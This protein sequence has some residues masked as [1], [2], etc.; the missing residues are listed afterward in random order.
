VDHIDRHGV[1]LDHPVAEPPPEAPPH[2]LV[3]D[4]DHIAELERIVAAARE[5][6]IVVTPWIRGGAAAHFCALLESVDP[7]V[8]VTVVY[9]YRGGFDQ[10]AGMVERLRGILAGRPRG[11]LVELR[12][13]GTHQKILYCD[14]KLGLVGS[15]NWLSNP[16]LEPCRR[17]L[18]NSRIQVRR[19]TSVRLEDAA[20]LAG[21]RSQ[22]AQ[23]LHGESRS[24]NG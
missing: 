19:E 12:N 24:L 1:V 15:W 8:R 14:G 22:I 21:L 9:G 13:E 20:T 2:A 5:E 3:H 11:E 23:L 18:L 7:T 10:D 16:Y 4:C 17:R 6:L